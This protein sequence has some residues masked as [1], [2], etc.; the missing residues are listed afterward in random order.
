MPEFE[1]TYRIEAA[2]DGDV[3]MDLPQAAV[4][5]VVRLI[6]DADEAGT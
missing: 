3:V 2:S 6:D 4:D 5:V 1:V